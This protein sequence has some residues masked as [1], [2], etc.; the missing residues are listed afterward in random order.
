MELK[1]R[2]CIVSGV[3]FSTEDSD[4]NR[5]EN[6]QPNMLKMSRKEMQC[7]VLTVHT[8]TRVGKVKGQ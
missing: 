6:K 2:A 7:T 4:A 3:F 5:E 8:F 1:E